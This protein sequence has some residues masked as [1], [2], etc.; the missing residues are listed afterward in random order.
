M[1]HFFLPTPILDRKKIMGANVGL[2]PYRKQGPR[3]EAEKIGSKLIVHNY[4]YGGFGLTLCWGGA[5]VVMSLLEKQELPKKIGILG[6][7]VIA[8]ATAYELLKRGF[9]V[10]L[11][12]HKWS[13]HVTS[14]VA[15]GI[16]TQPTSWNSEEE[17]KLLKQMLEASKKR[18]LK[19]EFLG[20]GTLDH[21]CFDLGNPE[22]MLETIEERQV[23]VHFDQGMTKE[24]ILF[25]ELALDG[26]LFLEDLFAQVK[27]LGAEL[28]QTAFSSLNSILALEEEVLINCTSQGARELFDDRSF[29][30]VRGH[31]VYFPFQKEINYTIY[32][33]V[34]DAGYFLTITPWNDRLIVG[35]V[36]EQGVEEEKVDPQIVEKL[37]SNAEKFFAH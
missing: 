5:S 25:H 13:P 37:I 29:H 23:M 11:Y 35:G 17:K 7:G 2:R 21:Y 20:I 30:L 10:T 19:K 24:A 9:H 26:K 15:A 4:G 12:A 36:Y 34:E 3:I 31:L 18:F 16:W 33:R 28:I 32:Q 14:N 1:E 22:P 27:M 8:L 6:G